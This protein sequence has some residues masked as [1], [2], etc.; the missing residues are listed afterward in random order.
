[1][2]AFGTKVCSFMMM[3]ML[4]GLIVCSPFSAAYA[5]R[6]DEEFD[7]AYIS[8]KSTKHAI[9][10]CVTYETKKTISVTSCWLEKKK[11]SNWS[12]ICS[13]EAPSSKSNAFSYTREMDY[14]DKIGTGTYRIGATFDADGHSITRYSNSRTF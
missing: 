14:S 4:L 7:S 9:Y 8:L 11:G 6:A 13:L 3:F 5:R 10:D 2:K 12:R 1:M